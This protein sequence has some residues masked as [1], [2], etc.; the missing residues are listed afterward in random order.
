MLRLALFQ[1]DIPQNAGTMIRMAACLGL[2][3]DIVE[4]A[5]FDVSDRHFRRSGMDYLERAAVS[6]HDSFR[7]FDDWRRA[8]GRRLVLAETDGAI[9]LPDFAFNTDD[10][11]MV[12]RESAGVT[13]EVRSAAE[14]VICIP[15]RPGLR[16]INV[17][18][19]AAM[20]MGEAL[21]Q[22]GG[23][24]GRDETDDADAPPHR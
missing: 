14:A 17:A 8:A 22:T 9:A 10:V 20:V 6:R 12:G 7:A 16:S 1:P 11:V 13:P 21:R 3:V 15:M 19:A 2:A 18:L 24:P 4:P 23:F 5:A